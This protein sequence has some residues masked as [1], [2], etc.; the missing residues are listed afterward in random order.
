V[1]ANALDLAGLVS[2]FCGHGDL[3]LRWKCG[4][5]RVRSGRAQVNCRGPVAG[6]G[7]PGTGE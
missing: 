7:N 2:A 1:R 3:V 4:P 5:R 6:Y